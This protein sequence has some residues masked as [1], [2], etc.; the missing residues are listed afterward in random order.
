[1][2]QPEQRQIIL[3]G[4]RE[5]AAEYARDSTL[6]RFRFS[7]GHLRAALNGLEDMEREP[8]IFTADESVSTA[9]PSFIT[10]DEIDRVLVLLSSKN[11]RILANKNP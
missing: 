11:P 4:L 9:R 7:A 1:M 6:M 8:L 10:Q 2:A 3:D 5:F